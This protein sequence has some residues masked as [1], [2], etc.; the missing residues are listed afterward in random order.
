MLFLFVFEHFQLFEREIWSCQWND[1]VSIGFIF[2]LFSFMY[3][4]KKKNTMIYILHAYLFIV[5]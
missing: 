4:V 3:L 5:L 1:K 2:H